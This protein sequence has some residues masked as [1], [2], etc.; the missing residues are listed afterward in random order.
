VKEF[1]SRAGRTFKD[2]NVE[3]DPEAYA[4]L[5]ALGIRTVPLTV[6]GARLVKGFDEQALQDALT[7][8]GEP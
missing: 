7:D 1:L 4:E 3:E 2:R 5:V 6:I 8:A